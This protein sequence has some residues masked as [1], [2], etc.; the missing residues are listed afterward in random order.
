VDPVLTIVDRDVNLDGVLVA[1]TTRLLPSRSQRTHGV[2]L[3]ITVK[4]ARVRLSEIVV[5]AMGMLLR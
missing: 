2:A 3:L 1:P 5:R 4:H